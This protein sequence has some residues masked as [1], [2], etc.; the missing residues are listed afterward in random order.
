MYV[1]TSVT[2]CASYA[3]YLASKGMIAYVIL[4]SLLRALTIAI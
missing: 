4:L 1:V 2:T 3:S